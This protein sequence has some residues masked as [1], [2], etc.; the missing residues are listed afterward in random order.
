MAGR[1]LGCVI[2]HDHEVR[3]GLA[4]G[5]DDLREVGVEHLERPIRSSPATRFTRSPAASIAWRTPLGFGR[6]VLRCS[7]RSQHR[8]SLRTTLSLTGRPTRSRARAS[9]D[10]S[11]SRDARGRSPPAALADPR[12]CPR[13][14]EVLDRDGST[15][16]SAPAP[17]P[18]A[19]PRSGDSSAHASGQPE[20]LRHAQPLWPKKFFKSAISTSF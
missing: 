18:P 2:E 16:S 8:C 1:Q 4:V 5:V 10:G 19:P 6:R 17:V 7:G 12:T 20:L 3:L 14:S 9:C 11:R 13:S 15:T